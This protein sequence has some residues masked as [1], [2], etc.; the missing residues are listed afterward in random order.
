MH[1]HSFDPVLTS[2]VLALVDA[3]CEKKDPAFD[4]E[5]SRSFSKTTEVDS[6][7]VALEIVVRSD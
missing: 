1:T 7:E 5:F 2:L 3:F 4:V 6:T